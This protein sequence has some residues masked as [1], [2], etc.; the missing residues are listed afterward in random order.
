[1]QYYELSRLKSE[2]NNMKINIYSHAAS[3]QPTNRLPTI[4]AVIIKR[5]CNTTPVILA[6]CN[7]YSAQNR[8]EGKNVSFKLSGIFPVQ[9]RWHGLQRQRARANVTERRDYSQQLNIY[10]GTEIIG[11]ISFCFGLY[12]FSVMFWG[13]VL[14][15][16]SLKLKPAG[17]IIIVN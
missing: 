14:S 2:N 8:W 15:V 1:M 4:A 9:C 17:I 5:K 11:H 12:I 6:N 7:K 13:H 10:C 16:V 3:P